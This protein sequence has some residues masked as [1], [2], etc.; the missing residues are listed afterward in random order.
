MNAT[1]GKLLDAK[2]VLVTGA[3]RG[4]GRALC[5]TFAAEGARVAF[6][7]TRDEEGGR[8]TLA[9]CRAAGT[10]A[11]AH[12][13]SALDAAATAALVRELEQSWGGLDI[14]VNNAA[15]TQVLPIALMDEED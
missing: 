14:L 4:L 2:R 5:E 3:S 6:T 7:W 12:R 9:Q 1:G 11:S 8:V 10:T 13:V 15:V